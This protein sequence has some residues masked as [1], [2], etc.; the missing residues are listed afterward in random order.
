MRYCLIPISI[1]GGIS[2]TIKT[3]EGSK[4]S[5]F[6]NVHIFID[7][8]LKGDH[9]I[10][11]INFVSIWL[12][13]NVRLPLTFIPFDVQTLQQSGVRTVPTEQLFRKHKIGKSFDYIPVSPELI[14]DQISILALA[15]LFF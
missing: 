3:Q 2:K 8:E 5:S 12:D 1:D 6:A 11:A 13:E 14:H 15:C 4:Q 10:R 9:E 7:Y